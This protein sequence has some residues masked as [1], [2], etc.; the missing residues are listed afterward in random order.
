MALH[1]SA[2]RVVESAHALGITI[3]VHEFPDGTHTAEDAARAVAVDVAQIVKSL[4]FSVDGRAVLALVSGPNRLDEHALAVATGQPNAPVARADADQ[5][6]AATGY[7]IGGVP[8]FGH[9]SP[10]PTYVDE[11]LMRHDV[12]WAAAG[13]PRHVFPIAP[14]DLVRLTDATVADLKQRL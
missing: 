6:R 12:V 5:A 14:G 8:P 10:I 13:T 4:V 3:D 2:Q 7:S 11:D 1:R 9:A